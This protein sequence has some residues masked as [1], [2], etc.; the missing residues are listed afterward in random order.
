MILMH[1]ARRL[2][3]S[4]LLAYS[5]HYPSLDCPV[6]LNIHVPNLGGQWAAL[7]AL[8]YEPWKLRWGALDFVPKGE[9]L[10]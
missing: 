9:V 7:P 10:R 8:D 2:N 3:T 5:L 4:L 6:N 1:M